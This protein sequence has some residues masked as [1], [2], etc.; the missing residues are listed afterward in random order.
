WRVRGAV[1]AAVARQ[2][3][4]RAGAG[5]G[6]AGV[7]APG[8][9]GISALVK[10]DRIGTRAVS[11]ATH[12]PFDFASLTFAPANR[13]VADGPPGRRRDASRGENHRTGA[14][15]KPYTFEQSDALM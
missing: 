3:A 6:T 10:L 11:R 2:A 12:G 1:Q 5:G 15:V 8:R 9:S 4:R 7:A 13:I 14:A